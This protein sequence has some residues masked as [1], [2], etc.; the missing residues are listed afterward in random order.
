MSVEG[1]CLSLGSCKKQTLGQ[2]PG[3]GSLIWEA[4]PQMH[5]RKIKLMEGSDKSKQKVR[6]TAGLHLDS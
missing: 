4:D 1:C 6:F 3:R 2:G 5:K